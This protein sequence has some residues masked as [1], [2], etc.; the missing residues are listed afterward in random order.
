MS[1]L[2]TY[3]LLIHF[4]LSCGLAQSEIV[5]EVP[6]SGSVRPNETICYVFVLDEA[7]TREVVF[8]QEPKLYIRLEPCQGVPHTRV[9]VSG[10]P[11]QGSAVNWDFQSS[12]MRNDLM[13]QGSPVPPAWE[14]PGDTE[15]LDIELSYR[16]VFVEISQ[17]YKPLKVVADL[18]DLQQELLA[19]NFT[20]DADVVASIAEEKIS[21]Q[22]GMMF[23]DPN[24]TEIL[25][26]IQAKLMPPANY[27]L[28]V[29]VHDAAKLTSQDIHPMYNSKNFDKN[30]TSDLWKTPLV[31]FTDAVQ[32]RLYYIV[33]WP[34]TGSTVKNLTSSNVTSNIS[35]DLSSLRRD[36]SRV[37]VSSTPSVS[38]HQVEATDAAV[39]GRQTLTR[40]A[41]V[42]PGRLEEVR[43][44]NEKITERLRETD[45]QI[46]R[47][48][49][50]NIP[51]V[52]KKLDETTSPQDSIRSS[53]RSLNMTALERAAI[54]I[55]P[56]DIV[57]MIFF[58]DITTEFKARWG[59]TMDAEGQVRTRL[60]DNP[61][62]SSQ[63][64]FQRSGELTCG[65]LQWITRLEFDKLDIN[66]NGYLSKDEY[67]L[68]YPSYLPLKDNGLK[69]DYTFESAAENSSEWGISKATWDE[70]YSDAN[71]VMLASIKDPLVRNMWTVCGV[72]K[73]GIP[74]DPLGIA[75]ANNSAG[76]WLS[77]RD[78]SQ[79]EDGRLRY[80]VGGLNDSDNNVYI[81]NVLARNLKTMEEFV[82]NP[83]VV[84]RKTP[85][86]VAPQVNG[87]QVGLIV[88]VALT[89]AAIAIF[90][91]AAIA[92]QTSKKMRPRLRIR[93][94]KAGARI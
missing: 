25:K 81:L 30:I 34:P 93:T 45:E 27:F 43:S 42:H 10:C 22:G 72:R 70:L 84:Q 74:L 53:R 35:Q 5:D 20:A 4:H 24:L 61:C 52:N 80:P 82:Y 60:I 51:A 75:V 71:S 19:R 16:R 54:P 86:Y 31:R 41:A 28:T 79:F 29:T 7:R 26:K 23:L 83:H 67:E 14:W 55:V 65:V 58:L 44:F 89:S 73:F 59:T 36:N 48:R 21:S 49:N 1:K 8:W 88:G 78:L 63:N 62:G 57:Y 68:R 18:F 91:V 6:T 3:L 17:Y 46:R 64:D 13:V 50:K 77:T 76:T 37:D 32:A 11:N 2:L 33:F 47:L 66:R 15:A 90:V 12:L 39:T 92:M 56:E 85:V 87:P 69:G 9:S 40:G 38:S 94:E